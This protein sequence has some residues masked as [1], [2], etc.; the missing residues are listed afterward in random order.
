VR[1]LK[2][3]SSVFRVLN[4][5]GTDYGHNYLATQQIREV[6]GYQ[7]TELHRYDELMGGKNEWKNAGNPAVLRLVAAKYV[8]LGQPVGATPMLTQVGDRPLQTHQGGQAYLYRF[9]GSDPYSYVVP[10]AVKIADD[11]A[12]AVISDPRSGF[13]PRKAI[14]VPAD[15]KVGLDPKDVRALAPADSTKVTVERSADDVIR[16]ALG[17]PAPANSYLFVSENFYPDWRATVDGKPADVLRAQFS[18]MAVPLPAG[19]K[20]VE[21]RVDP[22]SYG[23]FRWVTFA[24]LA[25]VIATAA[26]GFLVRSR[27]ANGV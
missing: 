17:T 25:L 10:T 12:L 27:T 16:L 22:A 6:L 24:A 8:V 26:S 15:S 4:P 5:P 18:L 11:Q 7:G 20:N 19:A 1:T 14:L 23:T 21:L 3:D 2:Q 9:N 13:D